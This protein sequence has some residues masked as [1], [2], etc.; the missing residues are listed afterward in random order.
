MLG[1]KILSQ[2]DNWDHMN[3]WGGGWMWLWG[4]AMMTL[5][6]ILVVWLIRTA[7]T[8]ST[9]VLDAPRRDP[10]DR[11]REILGE[12]LAKGELSPEEY[13]ERVSELQ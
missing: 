10:H 3:G 8:R 1:N 7:G 4:V 13:R 12:R 6:V 2:T 11:A 5:F 9:G